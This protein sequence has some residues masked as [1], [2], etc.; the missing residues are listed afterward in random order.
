MPIAAFESDLPREAL[1]PL[2]LRVIVAFAAVAASTL[3]KLAAGRVLSEDAQ[4]VF[5]AAISFAA[6]Y[7]GARVGVF[8]TVLSAV[9]QLYFFVTPLRSFRFT[10]PSDA[11]E[12]GVWLLEGV[13]LCALFHSLETARTRAAWSAVRARASEDAYR[14]LFETSPVPMYAFDPPTKKMFAVND[15]ALRLY[16]YTKGDFLALRMCD[17]E[18][19][20]AVHA[21]SLGAEPSPVTAH[22]RKDGVEIYVELTSRTPASSKT[23]VVA[24]DVS[25]K[26]RLEALL[27]QSQKMEAVGRLAGG[28]AHDFNNMLTII[29]G[30]T[31]MMLDEI[32]A[33]H[34]LR[35]SLE[36]V[37]L[38]AE[39]SSDLTRQLLLFSRQDAANV[40]TRVVDL[41]EAFAGT[42][43]MAQRIME[44]NIDVRTSFATEVCN[45]NVASGQME[46][47]LMNLMVNARDAMP[48]GGTLDVS[49]KI[50]DA[51]SAFAASNPGLRVGRYVK[52]TVADNGTGM[53]AETR[54]RI[55]EPFFTTKMP[56][57]GTGL[58]LATVFAIIRQAGGAVFV[59]SEVGKGTT[60]EI[61]VPDVGLRPAEVVVDAASAVSIAATE[62]IL[63]VE[64]EQG[65]RDLFHD[66]LCATGYKV[67]VAS[68]PGA[69]IEVAQ[70][71]S[72]KIDL[73]LT[74]VIMPRMTGRDLADVLRRARPEMK[75]VYMSGYTDN[76]VLRQ[77]RADCEFLQKPVGSDVLR[78]TLRGVLSPRSDLLGGLI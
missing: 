22:V 3:L 29:L 67:L 9:A 55:F 65:V 28:V 71:F 16:G 37:K 31:S 19:A 32:P 10:N 66:V 61:Y 39:R 42:S 40:E 72:G 30:H 64:D 52:L 56:G 8:A 25:E 11:V 7:G 43:K 62:T 12:L 2:A 35:E 23:V 41:N 50:V 21:M 36:E 77:G 58:G 26:R 44:E 17:L 20:D 53:D 45:A 14:K 34:D 46:Q 48:R 27:R 68:H 75:V 6:W 69:A 24:Q 18:S 5:L 13:I 60:F 74:D 51:D 73:L 33:S 63:L 4:L 59:T 57:K 78:R 1:R 76:V 54:A 49:T 38:A 47:V 15:A 70:S